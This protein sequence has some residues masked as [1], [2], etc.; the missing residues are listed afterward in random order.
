MADMV[1]HILKLAQTISGEVPTEIPEVKSL[2]WLAN[3]WPQVEKPEDDADRMSNAIHLYCTA[4]ADRMEA[5]SETVAF[6]QTINAERDALKID[7]INLTAMVEQLE[8]VKE[9]RDAMAAALKARGGCSVCKYYYFDCSEEPC[10]SC[11]Q[12]GNYPK[13]EWKGA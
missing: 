11:R 2:R 4:A 10:D 5:M 3:M 9:E 6:A 12:D 13:W 8:K 7:K 1:D